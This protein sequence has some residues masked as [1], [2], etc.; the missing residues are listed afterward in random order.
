MRRVQLIEGLIQDIRYAFRCVGKSPV[1][2]MIAVLTLALGI[3]ASLAILTVIHSVLLRTLPF[4]QA[5]RLVVLFATNPARGVMRDTT[6]FPDFLDWKSQSHNFTAMAAWRSAEINLTGAGTP[7]PIAGLRASYELFDVLGVAPALGRGFDKQEQTGRVPVALIGRGLWMSRFG[8]SPSVLGKSIVLDDVPH[9]VIGVLPATFQFPSFADV[10]VVVP[11]PEFTARSRGYVRAVGRLKQ[12]VGMIAAQQ[13]LDS[14]AAQLGQ[15]FPPTNRGRGVSLVS[16]RQVAAGDVRMP[17]LVLMG[18]ALF[19]LLIGCANVGNL[20]LVRGIARRRELAVRSAMG[21]GAYRLIRQ[22]LTESCVLALIASVLGSAI[23]FCGSKLLAASLS[24]RFALPPVTFDWILLAFAVW[25]SLASG[26]LCGLPPALIVWKSQLSDSLKEGSRGHAGGRNEN[27]LQSLLVTAESALTVILIV[28]AG[29]LMKSFVLLQQ[30]DL[31]LNPKNVLMAD[32]LLSK[33]YADLERRETFL[34]QMMESVSTLPG[35]QQVAVHTD[36]PFLGGG[37]RE[38]FHVEDREDPSPQQG[39]GI[40]FNVVS[41][42]FFSAMGIPLKRGRG[43]DPRDTVQ[44]ASVVIVNETM[45]RQFWPGG[46]AIGKRI[47]LY[48]DKDPQHWLSV[49]GVAGDVRY[50]GRDFDPAPQVFVPYTQNPYRFLPYAQGPNVSLIVRTAGDPTNLVRALQTKIWD[51]DPDQPISGIQTMEQALSQSTANRRVYGLLLSV[52]AFIALLMASSGLYG[53]VSY[54]VTRRTQEIG[55]RVALGATEPTIL[56]LVIRQ[57]LLLTLMG[58]AIGIGG[59]LVL[60]KLI[61]GLLYGITRTDVSTLIG[62]ALLFA[63]VAALATY[64]PARRA[65]TIDPTVAFRCE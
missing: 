49:V 1:F 11:I 10:D 15:S 44:A 17:L 23:A 20:V 25:I 38:T 40:A 30:T 63:V 12:G 64:F 55:I 37:A 7:K 52:F 50:R 29:L 61:A 47:R 33:R 18:A 14:I 5:D 26:L 32:L 2:A 3:G 19:V 48:Y 8:G 13:E 16:L 6:S 35:V 24:Q 22:L 42:D 34:R 56:A 27:R 41:G 43:F 51:T 60:T 58:V 45:A 4:P 65:A 59:S 46:D 57:G 54:A 31:G 21:A 62:T 9:S 28:G 53:L 36:P 39:H